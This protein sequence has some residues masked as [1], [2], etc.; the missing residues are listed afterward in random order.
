MKEEGLWMKGQGVGI[1]RTI[2]RG[3]HQPPECVHW[4]VAG[5]RGEGHARDIRRARAA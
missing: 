3:G 4:A 1:A 2:T 5:D